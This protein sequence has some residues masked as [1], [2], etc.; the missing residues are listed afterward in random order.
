MNNRNYDGIRLESQV[1]KAYDVWFEVF[2]GIDDIT[3][4]KGKN[5]K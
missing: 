3:L 5:G 4:R 1:C 2:L